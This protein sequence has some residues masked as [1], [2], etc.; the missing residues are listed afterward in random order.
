MDT[1]YSRKILAAEIKRLKEWND[2]VN[3]IKMSDH[4]KYLE[5][6]SYYD[7]GVEE[8][9]ELIKELETIIDVLELTNL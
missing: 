1:I 8:N 9:I 2:E 7:N 3:D 6:Q 4:K 5:Y